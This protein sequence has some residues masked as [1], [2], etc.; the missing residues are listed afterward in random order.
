MGDLED[1]QR[2]YEAFCSFGSSKNLAGGAG[3]GSMGDLTGPQMDGERLSLL[4]CW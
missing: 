2:M 1:L 4:Q 3:A